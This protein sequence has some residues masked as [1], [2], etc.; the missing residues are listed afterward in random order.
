MGMELL[1]D[2]W[3]WDYT[4]GG[5]VA[6]LAGTHPDGNARPN[7]V[8]IIQVWQQ[9]PRYRENLA[10]RAASHQMIGPDFGGATWTVCITQY[11]GFTWKALNGWIAT[12]TGCAWYG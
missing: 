2:D 1:I 8:T 3:Y 11:Y 10:G 4:D 12:T 6:Y 7:P 5:N 9:D